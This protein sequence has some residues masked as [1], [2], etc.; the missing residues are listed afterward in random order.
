[1]CRGSKEGARRRGRG[2]ACARSAGGEFL[3]GGEGGG[4]GGERES[5]CREAGQGGE[6]REKRQRGT[7]SV[8]E[9]P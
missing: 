9:K 8:E 7:E 2:T 6:G 4:G 5:E 3:G 1:M